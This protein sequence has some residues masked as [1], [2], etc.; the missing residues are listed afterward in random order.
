M[1]VP[2]IRLTERKQL[3][4]S[5][6]TSLFPLIFNTSDEDSSC[7]SHRGRRAKGHHAILCQLQSLQKQEY[8][9]PLVALRQHGAVL[10]KYRCGLYYN[11]MG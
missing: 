10:R 9:D 1:R 2:S 7:Q 4:T 5:W 8:S 6:F 11:G 3:E